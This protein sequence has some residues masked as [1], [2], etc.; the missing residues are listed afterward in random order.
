ML[1]AKT[2]KG[3][4]KKKNSKDGTLTERHTIPR[5]FHY[6]RLG[7]V[8]MVKISRWLVRAGQNADLG[9]FFA[10]AVRTAG[11]SIE[12]CPSI[13]KPNRAPNAPTSAI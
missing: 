10:E 2:A 4:R 12:T 9:R 7:L 3:P 8:V 11:T 6:A 13:N 1:K 5:C